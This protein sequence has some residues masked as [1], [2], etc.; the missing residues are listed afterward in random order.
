VTVTLSPTTAAASVTSA[1][2]IAAIYS[3][4]VLALAVLASTLAACPQ[5]LANGLETPA[6]ARQL[7]TV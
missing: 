5:N 2:R 1:I 7:I 4:A 6:S 3:E